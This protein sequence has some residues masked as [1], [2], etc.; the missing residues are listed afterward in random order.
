M[1]KA[2]V[3]IAAWLRLQGLNWDEGQ[4]LHPDERFLTMVETALALPSSVA[5]YLDTASSPLNPGNRGHEFF[6]Y[7]T[8][9]I[10]VV[11]LVA[12]SESR[13]RPSW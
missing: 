5:H 11:R 2:L 10:F 7:G 4:H 13:P 9:P 8:F 12:E 3:I 6:V 1:L